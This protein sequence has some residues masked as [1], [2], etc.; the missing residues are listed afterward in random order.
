M[1]HY[2]VSLDMMYVRLNSCRQ[3]ITYVRH[4]GRKEC[5]TAFFAVCRQMVVDPL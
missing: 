5:E 4:P 3:T 2:T 1:T